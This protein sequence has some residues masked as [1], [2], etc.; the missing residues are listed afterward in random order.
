MI[1]YRTIGCTQETHRTLQ[2]QIYG[3]TPRVDWLELITTL[4]ITQIFCGL[5]VS[6]R[7][8]PDLLI[9]P[10]EHHHSLTTTC[11]EV[12]QNLTFNI[13]HIATS[14]NMY[15]TYSSISRD[16]TYL[17][18]WLGSHLG[19]GGER[20]TLVSDVEKFMKTSFLQ[21]LEVLSLHGMME[22][23]AVST[24]EILEKQIEVS[25]HLLHKLWLLRLLGQE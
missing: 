22:S 3:T 11:F 18:Q 16:I 10:T 1:A 20:A 5:P 6:S 23:V 15:D 2:V 13:G 19:N 14:Y 9:D 24:L 8:H 7:A 21:W 4:K 25:I 12:I 17:C